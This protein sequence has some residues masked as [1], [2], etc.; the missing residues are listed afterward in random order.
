LAFWSHENAA[1]ASHEFPQ[2]KFSNR[3][4]NIKKAVER[5]ERTIVGVN[6]YAMHEENPQSDFVD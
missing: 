5:G 2:K 6:K 1:F 3:C 4:I